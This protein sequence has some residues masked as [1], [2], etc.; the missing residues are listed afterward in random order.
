MFFENIT[1]VTFQKYMCNFGKYGIYLDLKI[2]KEV[3]I[4][5]SFEICQNG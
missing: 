3:K 1:M 5:Q 2:Y 4:V